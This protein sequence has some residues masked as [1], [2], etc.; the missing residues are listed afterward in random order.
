MREYL[1]SLILA[2]VVLAS[3]Q[4]V[5]CNQESSST[6][7]YQNEQYG[8]SL[9]IPKT[10]NVKEERNRDSITF[11]SPNNQMEIRVVVDS[12]ESLNRFFSEAKS[13]GVDV[14]GLTPLELLVRFTGTEQ[15]EL[16]AE[17]KRIDWNEHAVTTFALVKG[18]GWKSWVKTLCILDRGKVYL[19]SFKVLGYS[20]SEFEEYRSQ[21]NQICKT[22]HT[23][24]VEGST[25]ISLPEGKTVFDF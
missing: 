24:H 16:G 15:M 20:D 14:K 4:V 11:S 5:R 13:K 3:V 7:V 9:K 12:E 18:S 19:I 1:A 17:G 21:V 2:I 23:V 8:Y 25:V 6:E 10:W 22:V